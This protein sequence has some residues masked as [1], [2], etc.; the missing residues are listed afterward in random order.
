MKET[1][2]IQEY[3]TTPDS[4]LKNGVTNRLHGEIRIFNESEIHKLANEVALKSDANSNCTKVDDLY[5]VWVKTY[6]VQEEL[7]QIHVIAT[8]E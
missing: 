6:F 1:F 5:N 8:V 2:V 7:V 3:A 4:A